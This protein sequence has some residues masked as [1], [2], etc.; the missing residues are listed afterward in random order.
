VPSWQTP[1]VSKFFLVTA[2]RFF[3]VRPFSNACVL[4]SE[5]EM[6]LQTLHQATDTAA[7]YMHARGEHLE[8]RLFDILERRSWKLFMFWTLFV[9]VGC[10]IPKLVGS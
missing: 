6:E 7:V 5:L 8:E 10:L 1:T 2:A 4:L 3:L 9:G